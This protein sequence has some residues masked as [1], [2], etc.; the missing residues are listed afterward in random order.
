M[1]FLQLRNELWK[2]F[3]KKRTYI[4]FGFLLAIQFLIV[5]ILHFNESAR[6]QVQLMGGGQFFSSLTCAA[7]M[8]VPQAWVMLPLYVALVGGDLVA[9]EAEEGT[10]RMVLARPVSRA[11]LLFVKWLSGVFFGV[12]LVTVLGAGALL[13]SSLWFSWGGMTVFIPFEGIGLFDAA[14]GFKRYVL[15]HLIMM[16]KA[17]TLT[18]LAFMF[19]CFNIRPAAATVMTISVAV[20][21]R[22]LSDMP[23]FADLKHFFLAAHLNCW[24]LVFN[25]PIPWWRILGSLCLL[26]GFNATFVTIGMAAFQVRDIKS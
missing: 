18:S 23:Y 9:K 4:G 21:D 1:F 17:A 14:T 25:D 2:L 13:I 22:V 10:L 20:A 24:G 16:S 26:V 12:I 7:S 11:R 19:S 3:G 6:R 5:L 8:F 15:G